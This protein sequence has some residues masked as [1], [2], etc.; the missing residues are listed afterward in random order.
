M[1]Y[2]SDAFGSYTFSR[3]LTNEEWQDALRYVSKNVREAWV[4]EQAATF[5]GTNAYVEIDGSKLYSFQSEVETL[6]Q[7]FAS[8]DIRMNGEV[9][10]YGEENGDIWRMNVV[11]NNAFR[12]NAKVVWPDGSEVR[13]RL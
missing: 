11:D 1:G 8:R 3:A 4:L 2:Y 10:V 5:N 6:A 9:V 12:E 13:T 7:Y